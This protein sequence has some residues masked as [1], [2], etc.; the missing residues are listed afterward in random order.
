MQHTYRL[1]TS[2]PD[3]VGIVARVSQF[4]AEQGGW[5]TEANYHSDADSNWFFMRNEIAAESLGMKADAVREAFRPIAEEYGME[6]ELVDSARRRRVVIMASHASHCI[7]DLLHRWHSGEL[8]CDI[9][10]VIS[11]HENLRSMVEWHGIPFEHVQ[12]DPNNK[13][14][15]HE[16][17]QSLAAAYEADCIVLARYMQIIPPE[18]CRA[19]AGRMINIHHSFLPSFVGANPYQ[20]A[21]DRGVKLIG[22]TSHYVTEQLDEGPIIEQDVI[23][24]SHRHS[25]DDLVRLGKD[26]EKSVL[27]RALRNHLED[28]VLVHGNKTVVFD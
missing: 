19:Y 11:N 7:A 27:A 28:R 13:A 24:V 1:I 4:V 3:R 6:W 23:R 8:Y 20:K 18:F 21:Y 15:A 17:V 9:P 12:V 22:A 2:C 10:C 26:V 16:K 5:L 14:P 25:K